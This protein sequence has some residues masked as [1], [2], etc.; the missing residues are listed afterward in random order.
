MLWSGFIEMDLYLE[1]NK[2]G[3]NLFQ[4]LLFVFMKPFDI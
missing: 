4:H 2:I 3:T 1:G